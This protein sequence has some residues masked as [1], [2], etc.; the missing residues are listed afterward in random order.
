MLLGASPVESEPYPAGVGDT[1]VG[2]MHGQRLRKTDKGGKENHRAT[3]S[4]DGAKEKFAH[5]VYSMKSGTRRG[6][7]GGV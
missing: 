6:V 2:D 3:P 4:L 5:K 1:G 7:E